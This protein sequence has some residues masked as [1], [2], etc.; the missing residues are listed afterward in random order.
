MAPRHA[1]SGLA[2]ESHKLDLQTATRER[3]RQERQV[4]GVARLIDGELAIVLNTI[5]QV[6]D[7]G[8]YLF[9]LPMPRGAWD[10]D[11]AL[12]AEAVAD[13]EA[14]ELVTAYARLSG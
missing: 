10:R 1:H 5:R 4:R 2:Q 8:E 11:G 7:S 9:Y 13:D 12:I 6:I 3:E 14:A